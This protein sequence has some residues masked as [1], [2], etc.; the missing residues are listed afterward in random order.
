MVAKLC[1][2]VIQ[3]W[4]TCQ[5]AIRIHLTKDSSDISEKAKKRLDCSSKV[6]FGVLSLV[7]GAFTITVIVLAHFDGDLM[8]QEGLEC[9]I[10][11]IISI[12]FLG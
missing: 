1:V 2:G 11:R 12:G 8:Q 5:L 9:Q 4:I 7:L 3:D 6:L 10:L